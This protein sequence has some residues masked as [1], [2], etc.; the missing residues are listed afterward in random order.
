MCFVALL[1][2]L[3]GLVWVVHVI[4]AAWLAYKRPS[5]LLCV[6]ISLTDQN[7]I[8]LL[9]ASDLVLVLLVRRHVHWNLGVSHHLALVNHLRVLNV[10]VLKRLSLNYVC[11]HGLVLHW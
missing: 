2:G 4:L 7:S 9:K 8:L 10:K 3:G 1:V 11:L 5:A 6:V